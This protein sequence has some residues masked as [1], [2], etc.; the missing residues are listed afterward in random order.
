MKDASEIVL[1]VNSTINSG[2]MGIMSPI[3]MISISIVMNMNPKAA[4]FFFT[5]QVFFQLPNI[6]KYLMP[7]EDFLERLG[8]SSQFWFFL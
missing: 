5:W 2:T 7:I 3:P 4:F 8:C 1:S 6:E